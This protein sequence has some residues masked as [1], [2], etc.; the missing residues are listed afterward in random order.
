[1]FP[2]RATSSVAGTL[3]GLGFYVDALQHGKAD[4]EQFMRPIAARKAEAAEQAG[5][6]AAGGTVEAELDQAKKAL[7]ALYERWKREPQNAKLKEE[8]RQKATALQKD[9]G[10]VAD[11]KL[12]GQAVDMLR[13]LGVGDAKP[14]DP[15]VS[16]VLTAIQPTAPAAPSPEAQKLI[17]ASAETVDAELL[18][19]Y[20]EEAGEVLGTIGESL[21]QVRD[22]PQNIEL[23]RTIR[24][25]FHTLKGSGRMVGLTRLGEAAWAVEQ[26]M[27]RWL[28]EERAAT[29]DLFTLIAAARQF[30]EGAVA[31]LKAN[32]P[33]ADESAIVAMANKVRPAKSRRSGGR[34]R[35]GCAG[36]R[37]RRAANRRDTAA[38]DRSRGVAP[39]R[40]QTSPRRRRRGGPACAARRRTAA[41]HCPFPAGGSGAGGA[42][43]IALAEASGEPRRRRRDDRRPTSVSLYGIFLRRRARISI[44]LPRVASAGTKARRRRGH[45]ARCHTLPASPGP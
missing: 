21:E 1:M 6:Q 32:G 9:A 19:V 35:P 5:E 15:K 34:D 7:N 22:L 40:A 26:V 2:R 38:G 23:L 42:D 17:A 16:Q 11:A 39:R 13:I 24:R 43:R 45:R 28:E 20:L 44:R 3:S 10:L 12:E 36:L 41:P 14:F 4:F 31:T 37:P 8:L 27:N 25:G 33:S 29:P 30:F 18:A